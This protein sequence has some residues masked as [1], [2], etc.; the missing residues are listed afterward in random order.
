MNM[1]A[2]GKCLACAKPTQ[3][4][5]VLGIAKYCNDCTDSLARYSVVRR[6]SF[7]CADGVCPL[8]RCAICGLDASLL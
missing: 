3:C 7:S 6:P 1:I 4:A 5:A 8:I 2:F